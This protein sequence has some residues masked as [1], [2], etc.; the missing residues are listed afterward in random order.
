MER[1]GGREG[2]AETLLIFIFRQWN[3]WE[4]LMLLLDDCL[5]FALS[6]VGIKAN[7]LG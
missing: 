5:I 6:H 3:R 1:T 2:C 4:Y 7:C